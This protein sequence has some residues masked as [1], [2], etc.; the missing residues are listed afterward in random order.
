MTLTDRRRSHDRGWFALAHGDGRRGGDLRRRAVLRRRVDGTPGG[1]ERLVSR[2][3]LDSPWGLALAPSSFGALSGDLLVG[4]FKSGSIDVFNPTT[5]ASQGTLNDP[6]GNPIQIDG[7]WALQVGN[8]GMGGDANTVYFTAGLD[9]ETHGL[10]GSL[11]PVVPTD[12]LTYHNNTSRTGA[13]L[14]ETTLT[15]QNVNA[16]SFGKLFGYDLDGQVYAQPL[17]ASNLRIDGKVRNVLFVATE[18]DSVYALDADN[19]TAGPHHNGVLWH[20]SFIKI[21]RAHV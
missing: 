4:N 3:P 2:G 9:H 8:G 17:V 16:S 21:G 19:P 18:N 15:P 6:A 13:N 5:G 12:V 7:L 10:F 11:T 1:Q 14:N 20:T